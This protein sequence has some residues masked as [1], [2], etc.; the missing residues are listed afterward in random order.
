MLSGTFYE[1]T[2]AR[3]P[4]FESSA[5]NRNQPDEGKKL[6]SAIMKNWG[7]LSLKISQVKSHAELLKKQLDK[8]REKE[9]LTAA[10]L[11]EAAQNKNFSNGSTMTQSQYSSWP[12]TLY[13]EKT[14]MLPGLRDTGHI[15]S[16]TAEWLGSQ[17]KEFSDLAKNHAVAQAQSNASQKIAN[18]AH[19][20]QELSSAINTIELQREKLVTASKNLQ[21]NLATQRDDITKKDQELLKYMEDALKGYRNRLAA[22]SIEK[23]NL[24][25]RVSLQ[26]VEAVKEFEA[27]ANMLKEEMGKFQAKLSKDAANLSKSF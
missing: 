23:N 19:N 4:R 11:S 9:A 20:I 16:R 6:Y 22:R 27:S 7:E 25:A 21:K 18:D 26:A 8:V 2:S 3:A 24:D 1:Q 5:V 12:N 14:G 15:L 10:F 17:S 13:N